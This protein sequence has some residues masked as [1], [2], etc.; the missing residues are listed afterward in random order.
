MIVRVKIQVG[1]GLTGWRVSKPQP[2]SD[3]FKSSVSYFNPDLFT[4][5][6]NLTHLTRIYTWVGGLNRLNE[7]W[8][9]P[10]NPFYIQKLAHYTS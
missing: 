8:V 10:F 1:F 7:F 6:P 9:D 3:Q 4:H 5:N 2:E